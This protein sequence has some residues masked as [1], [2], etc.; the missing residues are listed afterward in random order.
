MVVHIVVCCYY[1]CQKP[2]V[3]GSKLITF[4]SFANC[5]RPS[6]KTGVLFDHKDLHG[7]SLCPLV[8]MEEMRKLE[9][10]RSIKKKKKNN[11]KKKLLGGGSPFPFLVPFALKVNQQELR[12]HI[13]MKGTCE[14][15]TFYSTH[16]AQL[17]RLLDEGGPAREQQRAGGERGSRRTRSG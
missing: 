14:G 12:W 4:Q 2:T 13:L 6:L 1:Y 7:T 17:G 11:S 15:T 8:I 9:K 10:E 5:F 3:P 16:E